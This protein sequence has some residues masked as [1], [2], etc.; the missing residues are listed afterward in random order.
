MTVV[1]Y[2]DTN[3][4]CGTCHSGTFVKYGDEETPKCRYCGVLEG[5]NDGTPKRS[6]S[7]TTAKKVTN[8]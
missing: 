6:I 1:K 5:S 4:A 7:P 2:E 3:R 8:G